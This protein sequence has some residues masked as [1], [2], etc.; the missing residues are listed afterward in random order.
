MIAVGV[1]GDPVDL[2]MAAYISPPTAKTTRLATGS[3]FH[4]I[5]NSR[6]SALRA[7][8]MSPLPTLHCENETGH[9]RAVSVSGAC[10]DR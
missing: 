7:S 10:R 8:G 3:P 1:L 4:W 2:D 5:E 9:D 6:M